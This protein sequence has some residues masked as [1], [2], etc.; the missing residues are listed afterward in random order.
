[1]TEWD[2]LDD[3][4]EPVRLGCRWLQRMPMPPCAQPGPYCAGPNRLVV[5]I[6]GDAFY[7]DVLQRFPG[8]WTTGIDSHSFGP[9]LRPSRWTTYKQ[10]RAFRQLVKTARAYWTQYL[11]EYAPDLPPITRRLFGKRLTPGGVLLATERA[12][13][14]RRGDSR[15]VYLREA[16][17]GT[18]MPNV[19]ELEASRELIAHSVIDAKQQ[20]KLGATRWMMRVWYL[21]HDA[22][23]DNYL[24]GV[25]PPLGNVVDPAS[26]VAG[27]PSR[28]YRPARNLPPLDDD[29]RN[30]LDQFRKQYR[31]K[32]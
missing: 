32:K 13:E 15:L 10:R 28:A 2:L 24:D 8:S 3:S 1:M 25:S 27:Y 7:V 23:D 4:G 16:L 9:A 26:I 22:G 20:A 18:E 21:D 14:W 12:I 5:A 19:P 29:L 6:R 11:T 31:G 30:R 17:I